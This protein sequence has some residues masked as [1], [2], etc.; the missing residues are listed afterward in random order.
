MR[1]SQKEIIYPIDGVLDLHNFQPRE[2]KDLI[3]EYIS[4]CQEKG[5]LQIRIIHGKG[6][7]TLRRIVHASL[8]KNSQVLDYWQEEGSG[9]SWGATIVQLKSGD[10]D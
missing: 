9:G 6:T 3:S 5:I 2:V 1:D 7:G 8:D 10:D 4:V